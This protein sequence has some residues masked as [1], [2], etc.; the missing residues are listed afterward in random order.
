MRLALES[1]PNVKALAFDG[2]PLAFSNTSQMPNAKA[3]TATIIIV[4]ALEVRAMAN[5][6]NIVA[7]KFGKQRISPR[8]RPL[9]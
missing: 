4:M 2:V 1:S 8:T 3:V 9:K 6:S 5:L 7:P